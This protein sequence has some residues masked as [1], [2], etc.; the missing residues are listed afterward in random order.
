VKALYPGSFDPVTLGHLDLLRRARGLFDELVVAVGD[1]PAKSGLLRVE[2]RVALL[3]ALVAEEGLGVEVGRFTGLVVDYAAR[4]G[5]R[6][7]VRG[8]RPAGDLEYEYSMAS[9]NRSV[10]D[11]VD[12]VFLMPSPRWSFVSSRF[13]RE[14][15]AHGG[16]V[17]G[18]VPP[19]VALAL[20]ARTSN[21]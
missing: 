1:N 10:R 16:D 17:S 14:I 20:R 3:E 9:T 8:V 6:W 13:V 19:A 15:A 5:A 2:E 7:I 18:L 12:T 4:I 11:E 21:G